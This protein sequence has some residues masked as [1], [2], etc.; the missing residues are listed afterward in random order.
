MPVIRKNLQQYRKVY[1]GIRKTPKYNAQVVLDQNLTMETGNT[2]FDANTQTTYTFT[3][4]YT[5]VPTVTASL[6]AIT[7]GDQVNIFISSISTT[8]VS[9][10]ASAPNSGKVNLLVMG[11]SS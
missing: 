2:L 8:S 5:T 11:T 10:G 4:T 6:T 9:F 3:K 7:A 1:P